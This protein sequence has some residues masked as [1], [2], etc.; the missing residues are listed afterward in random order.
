MCGPFDEKNWDCTFLRRNRPVLKS[1]ISS[2][3]DL[4]VAGR[5][6][7]SDLKRARATVPHGAYRKDPRADT[8]NIC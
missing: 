5:F 2:L 4:Q 7:S 3:L 8:G 1:F 6:D